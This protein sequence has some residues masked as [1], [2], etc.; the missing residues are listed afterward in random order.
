L[1]ACLLALASACP[2][3]LLALACT[4]LHLLALACTSFLALNLHLNHP[5]LLTALASVCPLH[6]P[7]S[8]CPALAL[9]LLD[10]A[11]LDFSLLAC[12]C[13]TGE[14]AWCLLV[15]V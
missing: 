9:P 12:A 13:A 7:C 1:L 3:H 15:L 6:R 11:S 10:W 8:L 2:L 14:I 5:G 4:C